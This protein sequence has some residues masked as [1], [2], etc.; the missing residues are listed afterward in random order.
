MYDVSLNIVE[1]AV[2]TSTF[3]VYLM[4]IVACD[5]LKMPAVTGFGEDCGD[6]YTFTIHS[7]GPYLLS[8]T[9]SARETWPTYV[10]NTVILKRT[11]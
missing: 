5:H 10:Y 4:F 8:L 11:G 9:G 7:R 6:Y 1:W 2:N 3:D